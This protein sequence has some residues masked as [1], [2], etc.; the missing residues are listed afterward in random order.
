MTL[1][2]LLFIAV[3]RANLPAA[4]LPD[5]PLCT[6]T[7]PAGAVATWGELCKLQEKLVQVS[8]AN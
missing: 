4:T 7:C 1:H 3:Y 8:S 5:R 2:P 6:P